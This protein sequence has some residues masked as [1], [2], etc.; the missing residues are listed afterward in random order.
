[1]NLPRPTLEK[2]SK[3]ELITLVIAQ[4]EQIL[5]QSEQIRIQGE[6]IKT[7]ERRVEELERKSAKTA[8]PF[9]KSKKKTN[10]KGP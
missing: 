10:P 2:M 9:S 8:T 1:M 3:A 5:A 4:G 6:R 7:L